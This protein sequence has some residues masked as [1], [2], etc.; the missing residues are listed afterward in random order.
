MRGFTRLVAMFFGLAVS[1]SAGAE[2]LTFEGSVS[3]TSAKPIIMSL[4]PHAILRPGHSVTI[5]VSGEIDVNPEPRKRKRCGAIKCSKSKWTEHHWTTPD[6]IGISVYLR[7]AGS[8]QLGDEVVV[9]DK[10]V[11]IKIPLNKGYTRKYEIVATIQGAGQS[12][13][14]KISTG[15][16]FVRGKV[17]AQD[18]AYGLAGWL[19]TKPAVGEATSDDVLDPATLLY[20]EV[21]A[22]ALREHAASQYGLGN[23]PASASDSIKASHQQLMEK[24]YSVA[25]HDPENGTALARFYYA[26]GLTA[27]ADMKL[28]EAIELWERQPEPRSGAARVEIGKAYMLRG[29]ALLQETGGLDEASA[30][31]AAAYFDEGART[32][33]GAGASD[34]A[35][36]ALLRRA[37]ILRT[38]R[39]R[40]ALREA[41]RSLEEALT[42]SPD[43]IAGDVLL[44]KGSDEF[45][46]VDWSLALGLSP[47][48]R[49]PSKGL[50]VVDA[51]VVPF[52]YEPLGRELVTLTEDQI[53]W[54]PLTDLASV[55]R[56]VRMT[57][58]GESTMGIGAGSA[59][60]APGDGRIVVARSTGAVVPLSTSCAHGELEA[61]SVAADGVF[62]VVECEDRSEAYDLRPQVPKLLRTYTG[63]ED[64]I[65]GSAV[66]GFLVVKEL[67]DGEWSLR[68]HSPVGSDIPVSSRF[69]AERLDRGTAIFSP[70]ARVIL[71]QDA[72]TL[73]VHSCANGAPESPV[74]IP[75]DAGER[76]VTEE[77]EDE[78]DADVAF[79]LR[80]LSADRFAYS[81]A[82]IDR[83]YVVDWPSRAIKS[84]DIWAG[85]ELE[86]EV[87]M[88][89]YLLI[90]Q[91]EAPPLGLRLAWALRTAGASGGT[92]RLFGSTLL[93]D[94]PNAHLLS[95]GDG[96]LVSLG[97]KG[98]ALVAADGSAVYFEQ[99]VAPTVLPAASSWL[100]FEPG[101]EDTIKR[102][103][104][105]SGGNALPPKPLPRPDDAFVQ[106]AL[107]LAAKPGAATLLSVPPGQPRPPKFTEAE[108]ARIRAQ[109]SLITFEYSLAKELAPLPADQ[110]PSS[111]LVCAEPRAPKAD[112]TVETFNDDELAAVWIT[113][114]SG[115]GSGLREVQGRSGG[116][117]LRCLELRLVH[118]SAPGIISLQQVAA[119]RN[120]KWWTDGRWVSAERPLERGETIEAAWSDA[121]R[122]VLLINE[123][124]AAYQARKQVNPAAR[125]GSLLWELGTDGKLKQL[126]CGIIGSEATWKKIPAAACADL[127][128]LDDSV[129]CDKEFRRVV[130]DPELTL[131]AYPERD[132]LVVYSLVQ[133]RE[134]LRVPQ[135]RPVML[136]K[137]ALAVDPGAAP[138]GLGAE[139]KLYRF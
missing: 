123:S 54:R 24:A 93:A 30:T 112:G 111:R 2:G 28:R 43:R 37:E 38:F 20:P 99:L 14:P 29:E 52:A 69:V 60:I 91:G 105:F 133:R 81:P 51:H 55:T 64:V 101:T 86:A 103:R 102:L 21:V 118:G 19:T 114:S 82:A 34:L 44:A 18:R 41:A 113:S 126:C 67:R 53:Q 130:T 119:T 1:A 4:S 132:Q 57:P 90:P 62:G 39:T 7:E 5:E 63:G 42:L 40:P 138:H 131:V 79:E 117:V 10:P 121:S 110:A 97:K 45:L 6:K 83:L 104:L 136:R 56:S 120:L 65:P 116:D 80:W 15:S 31:R 76:R 98:A 16:Y 8:L 59:L 137:G 87:S 106:L 17:D 92:S 96:M 26:I 32:L 27:K 94:D 72:G 127:P 95:G 77:D 125:S 74:S 70:D 49:P 107:P 47:I 12:V 78:E 129:K 11:T 35:A 108:V 109:P 9:K 33:R 89:R 25:P 50:V 139:M 135:G 88:I 23:A 100:A 128:L 85:A 22:R 134:V 13:D 75:Q 68:L 122:V 115:N 48:D 46:A 58:E 36:G 73:S 3:A 84:H 124:T 66:C 71:V 61:L